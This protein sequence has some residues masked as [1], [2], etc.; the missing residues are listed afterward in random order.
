LTRSAQRRRRWRVLV[1]YLDLRAD[2]F[3]RARNRNPIHVLHEAAAAQQAVVRAHR[4]ALRLGVGRDHVERF[5]RR[6]A[7]ALTLP[8]RVSMDPRVA[9]KDPPVF[10]DD[11]A[12][13]ARRFD[14]GLFE[15]G[16]HEGRIVAVGDEADLLAIRLDGYRQAERTRQL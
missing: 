12:F 7:E 16:I 2:A 8:H 13:G 11:L 5:G 9:S 10:A 1:A 15:I 6:N 14:A 4:D 3:A